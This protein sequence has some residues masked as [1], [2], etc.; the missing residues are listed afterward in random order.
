LISPHGGDHD[1]EIMMM[2]VD[3]EMMM[4]DYEIMMMVVDHEM[5]VDGGR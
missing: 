3:C 4:V 1:H 2:M 5:V